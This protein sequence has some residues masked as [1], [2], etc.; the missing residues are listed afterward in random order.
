M[1]YWCHACRKSFTPQSLYCPLCGSDFIEWTNEALISSDDEDYSEESD[2]HHHPHLWTLSPPPRRLDTSNLEYTDLARWFLSIGFGRSG[3]VNLADYG[4]GQSLDDILNMSFEQDL[5]QS[6]GPPPA[7][8]RELS[9]LKKFK[10]NKDHIASNLECTVCTE[11]YRL[12]ELCHLLP[13]KHFFHQDCIKPW[14]QLHNTCPVCRYELKTDNPDYEAKKKTTKPTTTLTTTPPPP[15]TSPPLPSSPSDLIQTPPTLVNTTTPPPITT[16][17]PP[18]I[19][20]TPLLSG[21][22]TTLTPET[23]SARKVVR[24]VQGEGSLG[25][26]KSMQKNQHR[27]RKKKRPALQTSGAQ[28]NEKKYQ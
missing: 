23:T 5:A 12:Q 27:L 1:S 18:D 19:P 11:K 20:T 15:L 10:I 26:N 2:D 14:L 17:P 28:K 3:N 6:A 21:S 7:S 22:N 13:C 9:R 25:G 16:P 24:N 8:K 4:I